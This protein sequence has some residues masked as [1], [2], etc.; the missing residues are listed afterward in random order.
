MRINL[1]SEEQQS[2]LTS[3]SENTIEKVLYDFTYLRSWIASS[4]CDFTIIKAKAWASCH[5]MKKI[6]TSNFSRKLKIQLF[7]ATVESIELLYGSEICPTITKLLSKIIDGCYT[8]MLRMTIR[9]LLEGI[10]DQ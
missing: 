6:W 1:A 8:R 3:S 2:T 9:Y 7:A 4:E 10:Q 5:Q